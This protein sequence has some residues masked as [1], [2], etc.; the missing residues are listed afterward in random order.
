MPLT[1]KNLDWGEDEPEPAPVYCW[2]MGREV[3]CAS[4][5]VWRVMPDDRHER[6]LNT[7]GSPLWIAVDAPER[8]LHT[9][10]VPAGK[11]VF[12][13]RDRRGR[14]RGRAEAE[15]RPRGW[16]PS[17]REEDTGPEISQHEVELGERDAEIERLKA[18]L[19]AAQAALAGAAHSL[20]AAE[21]KVVRV[22]REARQAV[23]RVEQEMARRGR[24]YERR[25]D[26]LTRRAKRAEAR[27]RAPVP[28]VEA[29]KPTFV[30]GMLRNPLLLVPAAVK[31]A[32]VFG[33]SG[34]SD[35]ADPPDESGSG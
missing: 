34:A 35:G 11:Y 2:F 23:A 19:Q 32:T 18:E 9:L 28:A 29:A 20:E 8:E 21:S 27:A 3:P 26:G 4:V 22:E 6:V 14:I 31:L 15:M 24:A 5:E 33:R 25:V 1:F 30:K 10:P 13:A 16:Q 12:I 7:D 17:R